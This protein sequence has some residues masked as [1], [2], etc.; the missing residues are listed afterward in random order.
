MDLQ[1]QP[2]EKQE[3]KTLFCCF[4][5]MNKTFKTLHNYLL[6]LEGDSMLNKIFRSASW[7]FIRL[8]L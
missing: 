5:N 4:S 3:H 6:C 7:T 8:S 1:S 2:F